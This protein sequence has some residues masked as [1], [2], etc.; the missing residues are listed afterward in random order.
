MTITLVRHGE[1]KEP[2]IGCYNGHLDIGLS[3]K[4]Y[5]DAKALA[6]HFNT[7]DF[8]AIFCSDLIRTKETLKQF[9]NSDDVIYTKE[10]REKSWGKHEGLSFDAI[11]AQN[12][13]QYI[14]FEQWLNAL[15]GEDVEEYTLRVKKFIFEYLPTLKKENILL[16]T[17]SGVIKTFITTL[18]DI[19]LEEA[20]GISIPYASYVVYNSETKKLDIHD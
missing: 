11:I 12:E 20:F 8:D 14:N 3:E 7:S 2:Y 19:S 4:G 1:V 6:K 13:I 5:A 10:L 16:V 17:H 18:K 15:D 9:I